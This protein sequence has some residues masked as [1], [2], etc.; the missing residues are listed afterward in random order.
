[1][2]I[3][4]IRVENQY[5]DGRFTYNIKNIVLPLNQ[6][7]YNFG[8]YI[9]ST[10]DVFVDT[11]SADESGMIIY[12][13]EDN[14]KIGYR[15]YRDVFFANP[16]FYYPY[17]SLDAKVVSE[18]QKRQSGVK[19]TDFPLGVITLN[20]YIVGTEIPFYDNHDTIKQLAL[21]IQDNPDKVQI[22][23]DIYFSVYDRFE[24][25]INNE[26]F[27]GDLHTSNVMVNRDNHNITQIIDFASGYTK[28]GK[29]EKYM[30]E[31]YQRDFPKLINLGNEYANIDY[32][33]DLLHTDNPI[34]EIREE[35]DTMKRVLK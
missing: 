30:L 24:E 1:M 15:I 21:N 8:R 23:T 14:S 32:R 33:V 29:M 35:V 10:S 18:L 6:A 26:I 7:P 11:Y 20:N 12:Q 22:L 28:F 3:P 27:Y 13:D 34:E 4:G 16:N 25:F 5:V 17:G 9:I 31:A 2:Q 19:L